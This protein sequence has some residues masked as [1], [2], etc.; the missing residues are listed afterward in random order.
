MGP[1]NAACL[2]AL[3]TES[4]TPGDEV[5][6]ARRDEVEVCEWERRVRSEVVRDFWESLESQQTIV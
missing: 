3:L 2:T 6:Y 4:K 5:T 1:S